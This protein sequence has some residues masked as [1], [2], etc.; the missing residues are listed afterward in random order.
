[1][2]T[3]KKKF[4]KGLFLG[5]F[6]IILAVSWLAFGD[7]GFIYLYKKDKERQEYLVRI[8]KLEAANNELKDEIDRLRNDREYIEATARKELGLV[9][10]DEV[11]YRFTEDEK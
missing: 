5:L 10:K 7:R 11:I 8:Q 1:L 3:V 2:G 4:F 6:I 9:K